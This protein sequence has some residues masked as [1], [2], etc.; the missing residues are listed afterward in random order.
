MGK[1]ASVSGAIPHPK[2]EISVSLKKSGTG[3][4]ADVQL[5]D[6]VSGEILWKD[7]RHELPPGRSRL[8]F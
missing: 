5:P 7:A 3:V 2:G 1:L 8:V 6:G 4:E